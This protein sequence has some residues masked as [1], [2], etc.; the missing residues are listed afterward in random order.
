MRLGLLLRL[1]SI[2]YELVKRKE[3]ID[4]IG[5]GRLHACTSQTCWLPDAKLA[6]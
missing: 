2:R 4:W 1:P 6:I 5:W 3:S